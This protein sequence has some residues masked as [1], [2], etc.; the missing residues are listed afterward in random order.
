M[1]ILLL[2][3]NLPIVFLLLQLTSQHPYAEVFIGKPHVFT[4]DI[5]NLALVEE[6]IK[7]ILNTEVS[8]LSQDGRLL[9]MYC[10]SWSISYVEGTCTVLAKGKNWTLKS[11]TFFW[12]FNY[13]A[14]FISLV[15][16]FEQRIST[17]N[18]HLL[19]QNTFLTR[20][21]FMKL[22]VLLHPQSFTS[23]STGK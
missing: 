1:L 3:V 7:E 14:L 15:T 17:R 5:N 13:R 23:T 10:T 12:M 16:N 11:R 22:I 9:S 21:T 4:V 18:V 8:V 20:A 6:A 2:S 19:L